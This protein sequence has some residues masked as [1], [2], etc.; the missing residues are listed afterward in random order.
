MRS[1]DP[2][3]RKLILACIKFMKST[4]IQPSNLDK[5]YEV[6]GNDPLHQ[7]LKFIHEIDLIKV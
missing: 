7:Y 6:W 5:L 4:E 3:L 1:L 2:L